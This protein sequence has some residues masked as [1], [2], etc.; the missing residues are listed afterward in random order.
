MTDDIYLDK[1]RVYNLFI[2]ADIPPSSGIDEKYLLSPLIGLT[3]FEGHHTDVH[4]PKWTQMLTAGHSLRFRQPRGAIAEVFAA[5]AFWVENR[6]VVCAVHNTN[7]RLVQTELNLT[8]KS[9]QR[10]Q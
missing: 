9:P 3:S 6:L 2:S 10:Y 5:L 4:A 8:D 1:I 7:F